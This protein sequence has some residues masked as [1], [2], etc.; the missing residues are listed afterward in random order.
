MNG[1]TFPTIAETRPLEP[2]LEHEIRLRAYDLYQQRGH[3]DGHRLD[4]WLQAEA[5]VLRSLV[6]HDPPG[7]SET[8][9][10]ISR[11]GPTTDRKR[12]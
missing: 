12:F 5:E 1:T 10:E 3:A 8:L 6:S 2:M 11:R 9:S 4:D 7:P